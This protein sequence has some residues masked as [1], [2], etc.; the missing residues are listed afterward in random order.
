[1]LGGAAPVLGEYSVIQ[2]LLLDAVARE[3]LGE[4]RAAEADVE[5]ALDLAEPDALI[6]PF[7]MIAGARPA[8]TAPAP[9]HRPRRAAGGH[10]GRAGGVV[11]APA[12][13][14]TRLELHEDLSESELRVLRYLPSNLSA[15]EIA[16]ELFLSTSTVKTHMRHIYAK[17]G[18]H[19]RT[20]AVEHARA[21]GLLGPIRPTP[22]LASTR[23]YDSDDAR[24]SA[25]SPYCRSMDDH[26]AKPVRYEIR[27]RGVLGE[28]LLAAFPDLHGEAQGRRDACSTGALPDQAAL[29]GVLAQIEALGL[30]LLEVRRVP[31]SGAADADQPNR[32]TTAHPAG[33]EPRPG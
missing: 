18:A 11:V 28:T 2:A 30:E 25:R 13:R 31:Q 33:R 4:P 23:S 5:R 1:M 10:P 9:P 12:S 3:R 24:S 27:V 17:L 6:F 22:P 32:T 16:A 7:V 14:R 20:E 29:H 15:P 26:P 19:R 21:L 8:R